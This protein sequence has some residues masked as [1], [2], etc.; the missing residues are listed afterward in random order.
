[1]MKTNICVLALILMALFV[2][3]TWAF[4][5][6]VMF[7]GVTQED[8]IDVLEGHMKKTGRYDS[9]IV[10]ALRTIARNQVG[11]GQHY[12]NFFARVTV[13]EDVKLVLSDGTVIGDEVCVGDTI[14]LKTGA[15]KGEFWQDGGD[16]DTPPVY[17]VDDVE[18]T[19]YEILEEIRSHWSRGTYKPTDLGDG[20]CMEGDVLVDDLSGLTVYK[21]TGVLTEDPVASCLAASSGVVYCSLNENPSTINGQY[22]DG[23]TYT[24]KDGGVLE[25]DSTYSLKCA[26]YAYEYRTTSEMMDT[27]F[28][29][30]GITLSDTFGEAS[31]DCCLTVQAPAIPIY[32]GEYMHLDMSSDDLMD[33]SK[34]MSATDFY[35]KYQNALENAKSGDHDYFVVDRFGVDKT[36]RVV[37]PA[38]DD[39]E[40]S[41]P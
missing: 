4:N 6:K 33:I 18:E 9:G 16:Y 35:T 25:V 8:G 19:T 30:I 34:I 5:D 40:L 29:K 21:G 1:M 26:Y 23:A 28:S 27:F 15:A 31:G 2:S 11:S 20:T 7:S 41:V 10:S 37:Y 12:D 22:Y 17:W 13:P 32:V 39:V 38:D 3:S 14:S 36:L 24:V